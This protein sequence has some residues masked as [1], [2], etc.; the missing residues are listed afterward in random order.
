MREFVL[1]VDVDRDHL[2]MPDQICLAHV[3]VDCLE[4]TKTAFDFLEVNMVPHTV[5]VLDDW[6]ETWP[7][8]EQAYREWSS[9]TGPAAADDRQVS[10]DR[11]GRRDSLTDI[12]THRIPCGS[13]GCYGRRHDAAAARTGSAR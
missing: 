4:S 1:L 13:V 11:D 8:V 3:D 2:A 12:E 7:G 9:R 10:S 5:L 6:G